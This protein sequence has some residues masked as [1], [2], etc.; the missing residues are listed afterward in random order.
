MS[1]ICKPAPSPTKRSISS[2][3]KKMRAIFFKTKLWRNGQILRFYFVGGTDKEHSSVYLAVE[4][5]SKYVNL[6]FAQV[7]D[8]KYSDI[9]ISFD[10]RDGSWSYIGTD[11][12][13]IP[14]S[15]PTM[16]LG[17]PAALHEFGHAI[18]M[19]HEH[20]NPDG[21]IEWSRDFVLSTL[22]GSPNYWDD[23]TIY[24]NVLNKL[25]ETKVEGSEFD[26]DSI[27][28]YFFPDEWVKN[29][30]GTK[31]NKQLSDLDKQWATETYPPIAPK[32][33]W[34]MWGYFITHM[35]KGK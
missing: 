5:W 34:S 1:I 15:M 31:E 21:G 33:S 9:R 29:G 22:R 24:F 13:N 10:K 2:S 35:R 30:E 7:D 26:P 14:K 16:N 28:L 8:P 27:M 32:E 23:G 19:G 20:Q 25:D 12:K 3:F 17:F 4:E 18:G 6:Q 11:S